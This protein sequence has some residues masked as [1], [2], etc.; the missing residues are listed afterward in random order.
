MLL[1]PLPHGEAAREVP[2]ITKWKLHWTKLPL[3]MPLVEQFITTF[4]NGCLGSHNDEERSEMRY[5]MRIAGPRESSKFWTHI[6]LLGNAQ[7]HAYLSVPEPH[8]AVAACQ[9]VSASWTVIVSC[10]SSSLL[11]LTC[12]PLHFWLDWSEHNKRFG[13][14]TSVCWIVLSCALHSR[15]NLVWGELGGMISVMPPKMSVIYLWI[16]D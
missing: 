11:K 5:V 10:V 1:W 6:A 7:E 13:R 12:L 16:S 4:G 8:S 15:S 14:C 2:P 9:S 3:A